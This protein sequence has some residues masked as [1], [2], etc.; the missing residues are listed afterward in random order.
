MKID[1]SRLST[2]RM[3]GWETEITCPLRM[4]EVDFPCRPCQDGRPPKRSALGRVCRQ[5]WPWLCFV[6]CSVLSYFIVSQFIVTT[7]VVQGR[8]MAPTLAHGDRYLLHRWQLLFRSPERGD[9]VVVRDAARHDFIVKRIV[10]LPGESLQLKEGGVWINGERLVEPYLPAG[11]RTQGMEG[12]E[13]LIVVG[14]NRYFVMGDNREISED[15][16]THGA[17]LSDQIL[18]F[19]PQ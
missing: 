19:I 1:L 11:V 7:V 14:K 17:V 3:T 2:P 5:F 6:A 9:L 4:I 12:I 18:G 13:P 8:S 15:S 10:G 16:R